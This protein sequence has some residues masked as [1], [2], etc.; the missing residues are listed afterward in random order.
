MDMGILL[1]F[2]GLGWA[3]GDWR[4]KSNPPQLRRPPGKALSDKMPSCRMQG[5][6]PKRSGVDPGLEGWV[7][8]AARIKHKAFALEVRMAVDIEIL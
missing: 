1:L 5:T 6:P 7:Q 2:G 8:R 4:H 3:I